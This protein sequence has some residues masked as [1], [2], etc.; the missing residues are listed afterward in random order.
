MKSKSDRE[1]EVSRLLRAELVVRGIT[2]KN[3]SRMIAA[4]GEEENE[5]Q[6]KAKILRG[7]FSLEFFLLVMK[8]IGGG[9]ISVT[10]KGTSLT[11]GDTNVTVGSCN[12]VLD[13][14][15]QER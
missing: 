6:L 3:L 11:V 7:K 2:Y 13:R 5:S 8:A 9:G 14:N 1:R 12:N 10:S 15:R 4:V